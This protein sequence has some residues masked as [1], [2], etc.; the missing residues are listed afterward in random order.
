[1]QEPPARPTKGVTFIQAAQRCGATLALALG[2]LGPAFAH[3]PLEAAAASVYVVS[4]GW[5]V[6]LVLRRHDLPATS[7]LAEYAPG[8]FRYLEVGWGD[9]DFYPAKRGT[10]PLALRAAFRSRGPVLQVVGFDDAVIETFPDSKILQ[11]DLSPEGLASLA[12]YIDAT[13]AVDPDGRPIIV[14]PA[15]YGVGLFY[16]ARGRYGLLK[17]SNTWVA[18]GLEVAGCPI[19]VDA[20]VTAGAM[21]HQTARFAHVVRSGPLLRGSDEPAMRCAVPRCSSRGSRDLKRTPYC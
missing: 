17:N 2:L 19:D 4:H 18:R 13:Y 14:A 10:I 1:M 11:I 21:L 12:R 20:A 8:P 3:P 5:H 6:G 9:E 7:R 15:A 16:R